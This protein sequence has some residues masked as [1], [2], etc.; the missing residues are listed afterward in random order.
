MSCLV[1]LLLALRKKL[2]PKML[3]NYSSDV[4]VI[5]VLSRKNNLLDSTRCKQVYFS[6]YRYR[7]NTA[8]KPPHNWWTPLGFVFK[9][10]KGLSPPLPLSLISLLLFYCYS[11]ASYF[12]FDSTIFT[13]S[14]TLSGHFH[15]SATFSNLLAASAAPKALSGADIQHLLAQ[16][17]HTKI[18]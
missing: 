12:I 9:E 7:L 17:T 15:F 8:M 2:D 14:P 4:S 13:S 5:W 16:F 6:M 10:T 3:N 18:Q 1:H 11:A